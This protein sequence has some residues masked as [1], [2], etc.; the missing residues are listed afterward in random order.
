MLPEFFEF[1]LPTKVVFGPGLVS[2]FSAELA[3]IPAKRFFVVTDKIIRENGLTDRVL[4]GLANSGVETAGVFD[5]VPQNS[6]VKVCARA[7][8]AAKSSGAD[9]IIAVGGGS[10]I[11]TAKA[12]NILFTKGGDLVEDYSGA[13]TLTERLHPLIVIPTTSGTGS[14]VTQVAVILDEEAEVKSPFTDRYLLPDLAI[15]DPEMTYTMPPLVTA[16]TGM[17]AFTHAVEAYV[18]VQ[19]SPFSDALAIAAIKLVRKNLVKAC[20]DPEDPE[21]RGS[22]AIAAC[23]S[24]I[25][26]NHSMVGIV[27][28]MAHTIG[29]LHHV[30]HGTANSICLPFGMNYNIEECQEKLALLA[31]YLGKDARDL[32]TMDAAKLAIEAVIE[33]RAE[34]K[35]VA[36]LPDKLSD[37]GIKEENLEA[38]AEGTVMD[39]TSFYNP[40]E[41]TAEDVLVELKRAL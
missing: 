3:N 1:F 6:E 7:A 14:E 36:G 9:G 13:Q 21:A 32:D 35:N 34:L 17:D 41:V 19:A 38:I 2:D 33:L 11:D 27:H 25:A 24:G 29:G 8:E 4:E 20:T 26:F 30:A 22:M 28:G 5:D 16:A 40:R 31:H 12:A 15:L 23:Q 10:V 37:V 39:G 18:G